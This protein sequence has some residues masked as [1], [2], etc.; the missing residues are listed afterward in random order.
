MTTTASTLPDEDLE[1][2][3]QIAAAYRWHGERIGQLHP[4][5]WDALAGCGIARAC[6]P[7]AFGGLETPPPRLLEVVTALARADASAGWIA[8]IHA[9]AG[10]FPTLLPEPAAASILAYAGNA[11]TAVWIGGSSH[12]AGT[13]HQVPGGYRLSGSWPLVTGAH[14]VDVAFLAARLAGTPEKIG[15]LC[16]RRGGWRVKSDWDAH[17]LRGTDSATLIVDEVTVPADHIMDLTADPPDTGAP[18]SKFPR[19]GLLACCLAAVAI[20]TAE[21]AE[22]AFSQLTGRH[23][24]RNGS[25]TLAA[26]AT[27]QIAAA[28]TTARLASARLYLTHTV[29]TAWKS[30][31]AGPVP[32]QMR[33]DLRLAAAEATRAATET[34]RLLFE[35][36]GS[37]AIHASA[38]LESC[39]RDLA[40]IG[41]HALLAAPA[42]QRAG[43]FLLTSEC[44]Q[45]L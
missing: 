41:R 36:A 25:G 27:A 37:A 8:G 10:I 5:V 4:A 29:D 34:T 2:V 11:E 23:R 44:P 17:G 35:A 24:P 7:Q 14:H 9:P 33:A 42:H 32:E 39:M 38:E 28:Q 21:H 3:C 22:R 12:P 30:A 31:L 15:W 16:V 45:D 18:L 20:G 19:Y 13:A 43:R 40:V 26:Q 6:L 1:A